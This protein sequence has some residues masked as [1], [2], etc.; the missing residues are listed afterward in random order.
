MQSIVLWPALALLGGAAAVTIPAVQDSGSRS[1]L[2]WV[3]IPTVALSVAA[4]WV[5]GGIL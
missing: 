3:V 2:Y 5:H 1:I 4:L